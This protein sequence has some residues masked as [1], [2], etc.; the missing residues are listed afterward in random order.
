MKD[1]FPFL[2]IYFILLFLQK[3]HAAGIMGENLHEISMPILWEVKNKIFQNVSAEILPSTRNFNLN[4][5]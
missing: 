4:N 3:F 2:F 1:M 5:E